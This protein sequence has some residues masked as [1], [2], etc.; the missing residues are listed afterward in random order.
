LLVRSHI[1]VCVCVQA[2]PWR[3]F[4]NHAIS[5]CVGVLVW[6]C[7]CVCVVLLLFVFVCVCVLTTVS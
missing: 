7:L 2:A 6:W 4:E 1:C 5:P 3:R